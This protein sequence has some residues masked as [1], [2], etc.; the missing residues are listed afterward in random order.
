MKKSIS[1][2][3][4]LLVF[5]V[6]MAV[7]AFADG[8]T[9]DSGG[10]ADEYYRLQ[11]LAGILTE[12][13]TERV[14][15]L[16]D[17]ASVRL[18]FDLVIAT[19]DNLEGYTAQSYADEWYEYCKFGYGVNKD[20]AML[21]ISMQ[22]RDWVIS[23][24]GYGITAFTDAGIAYIGE[25]MGDDLSAGNYAD[26]FCTFIRFAN[27]FVTQARDGEPFDKADMPKEPLSAVWIV[28]SLVVGFVLAKIIVGSM[29]SQLKTV[30][31]QPAAGS[32]VRQG[33]MN[34]TESRELFLYNKLDRTEKPKNNS[35]GSSTHTSSSGTRHGGGGGK[36]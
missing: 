35:S 15:K 27:Q 16:L 17:E 5:C 30:R 18:K 1:M 34:I 2:I 10:F 14:Q 6:S 13:E 31:V 11:D 36:F 4:M 19:V 12:E 29:K 32:Y 25:R 7:P 20:G 26:A 3:L 9:K 8:E 23:T 24:C 21:L 28:I 33:S 22:E